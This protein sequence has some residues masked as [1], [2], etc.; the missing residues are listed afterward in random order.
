[1]FISCFLSLM[2]RACFSTVQFSKTCSLF[3]V[4]FLL[5]PPSGDDN[6][7][8]IMFI[9]VSQ[10]YLLPF[11]LALPFVFVL[12]FTLCYACTADACLV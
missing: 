12:S 2:N 6:D 4:A 7:Y 10:W 11:S 1:R 5:L 3:V 8:S 9:G